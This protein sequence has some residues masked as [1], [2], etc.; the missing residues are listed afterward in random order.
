MIILIFLLFLIAVFGGIFVTFLIWPRIKYNWLPQLCRWLIISLPFER[1]PSVNTAV[2]N[3][4]ISQIL[5]LIGFYF[6]IVLIVKKDPIL[7]AKKF[8]TDVIYPILFIIFSLPSWFGIVNFNRFLSTFVATLLTFGAFFLLSQFTENI[9]KRIQELVLTMV[10][11]GF[12]GVYQFLG[13]MIGLPIWLTGLREGYTKAVFGIPR[14]HVTAIEPLYFAGMLFLPIFTCLTFILARRKM[15]VKHFKYSNFVLLSFFILLFVLTLS[16]GAWFTLALTLPVYLIF[17]ARKLK[18]LEL[19]KSLSWLG[20]ITVIGF[21][22]SLLYSET[23]LE[24]AYGFWQ[25]IVSTLNFSAATS[26]ERLSLFAGA[27]MIL[28][29]YI[30]TGIGSG[31]YGIYSEGL[32][33]INFEPG[34][35]AIVNN[36]YLEIWLE[37]GLISLWIFLI[38]IFTPVAKS[39]AEF[40]KKGK[41]IDDNEIA[42][43]ILTFSLIAYFVQWSF[44]SPIFIM[45]IFIM[46]GMLSRLTYLGNQAKLD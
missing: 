17:A 37:F 30:I 23:I 21:L 8:N 2:G 25:H 6:L 18:V 40:V 10:F 5:V 31:Q 43:F 28:Q 16:K 33:P 35:F 14:I 4:R 27:W 7:K 42:K 13:D 36:V 1:I 20:F 3:I 24:F 9:Y 41:I 39:L 32:L 11:V 44:F 12:F 34:S 22:F 45:P 26:F 38:F 29:R 19:L 46:L 15:L